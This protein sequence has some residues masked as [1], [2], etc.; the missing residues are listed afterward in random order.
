[1]SR[2]RRPRLEDGD[3]VEVVNVSDDAAA[4]CGRRGR[5]KGVRGRDRTWS[6]MFI[7]AVG[8][9]SDMMVFRRHELRRIRLKR[10]GR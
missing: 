7:R 9:G 5:I 6:V 2:K 1:M 10:G 4:W 3:V 8:M